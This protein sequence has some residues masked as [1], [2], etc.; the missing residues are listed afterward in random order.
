MFIAFCVLRN[1]SYQRE[2]ERERERERTEKR[3]TE[4]EEEGGKRLAVEIW[5]IDIIIII[6]SRQH[7]IATETASKITFFTFINQ[8]NWN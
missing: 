7:C 4:I 2:R 6:L 5:I 1:N 8:S 3:W